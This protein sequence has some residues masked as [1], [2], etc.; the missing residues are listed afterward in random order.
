MNSAGGSFLDRLAAGEVMLADGAMGSLLMEHGLELGQP[1]ERF[2]LEHPELLQEIARA[3][4][5]A[6]AQILQTNTFG[7]SP[8]KLAP[9]GLAERTEQIQREAVGAVRAAIAAAGRE[10]DRVLE[11]TDV[12]AAGGGAERARRGGV[13]Y[14]SGSCGPCGRMLEP[15]GDA[16]PSLVRESFE[17]QMGALIDAGVDILCIETMTDLQEARLAVEAAHR[18]MTAI[19]RRVPVMTSMTY[20][21]TPRGF[22]TMMGQDIAT[23]AAALLE[24]GTDIVGSNCGNGIVNM[25]KIAQELR[26]VTDRPLLIQSNAGLPELEG[27]RAVYREDPDFMAGHIPALCE[28]GVQVIG[29]CCGTTPDHI[30]AFRRALDELTS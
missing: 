5:E 20:D 29:G 16:S 8:L 7:G 2:N 6:G 14:I 1:P 30:R 26:A 25:V 15:Y 24:S 3:Y 4:L 17:R 28:A 18:A 27:D 10:T 22:F 23:C 21:A 13:V 9:Y 19:S 11:F 12:E